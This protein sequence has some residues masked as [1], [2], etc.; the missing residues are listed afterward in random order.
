MNKFLLLL[1]LLPAM[2]VATPAVVTPKHYTSYPYG[3]PTFEC[4]YEA[5]IDQ[6]VPLDILLAINSVEMGRTGQS[7]KNKNKTVDTGA[8]QINTIHF[9]W[10][11]QTTGASPKDLSE[12]GCFNAQIA[13]RILR[14][15]INSDTKQH[16]DIL[17]RASNYHSAT[18]RYNSIYRA[19]LVKHLKHWQAWLQ[20][21]H[22]SVPLT[23]PDTPIVF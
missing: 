20:Y 12:R 17:T 23:N 18:Y 22:I 7:S 6:Q 3:K 9:D 10:I 14:G 16:Q 11:R 4:V 15:V 21:N 8:F 13:G 1:A 2:A 19:K 5:S